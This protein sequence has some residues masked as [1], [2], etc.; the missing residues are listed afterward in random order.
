MA[1][2][3]LTSPVMKTSI[4]DILMLFQKLLTR[5]SNLICVLCNLHI[6]PPLASIVPKNKLM[7][8]ILSGSM[9]EV[10]LTCSSI[11]DLPIS[12]TWS[13]N[14]TSNPIA[15]TRSD[16]SFTNGDFRSTLRIRN[17]QLDDSG[18]YTCTASN[19]LIADATLSS[20]SASVTVQITSKF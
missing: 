19:P 8:E 20:S 10:L 16:I 6:V 9:S 18:V 3:G 14:A 17:L 7:V 4:V 15:S 5:L 2:K 11:G 1:R 13:S 12:F